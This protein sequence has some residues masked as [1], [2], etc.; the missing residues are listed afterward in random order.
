VVG[1]TERDLTMHIDKYKKADLTRIF[2]SIKELGGEEA[3]S[4]SQGN[5][6]EQEEVRKELLKRSEKLFEELVMLY[7]K[8]TE[9]AYDEGGHADP[10]GGE[11]DPGFCCEEDVLKELFSIISGYR[12]MDC[13]EFS[14]KFNKECLK[15]LGDENRLT[16]ISAFTSGKSS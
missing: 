2:N 5:V 11:F 7:D 12:T 15:I 4:G 16:L 14:E 8:W 3:F 10:V 6:E 1:L 9:D 13:R